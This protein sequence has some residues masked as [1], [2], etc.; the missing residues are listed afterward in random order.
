M[1]KLSSSLRSANIAR[2]MTRN[3][4]CIHQA[5]S[6]GHSTD[7][8]QNSPIYEIGNP[9]PSYGRCLISTVIKFIPVIF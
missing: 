9:Q 8:S 5:D 7:W 3:V 1:G 2:L 4:A 6:V